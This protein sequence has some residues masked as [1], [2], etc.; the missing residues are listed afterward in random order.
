MKITELWKRKLTRTSENGKVPLFLDTQNQYC[1]SGHTPRA[2][3]RFNAIS[4]KISVS[5][6]IELE[7]SPGIDKQKR[8]RIAKAISSSKSKARSITISDYKDTV[9]KTA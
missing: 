9:I 7:N 6:L 1:Q 3:H 2:L 5:F 8:I 4:V